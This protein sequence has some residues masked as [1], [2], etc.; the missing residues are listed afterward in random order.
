[1]SKA[2]RQIA[3]FLFYQYTE[4]YAKNSRHIFAQTC[5]AFQCKWA[6]GLQFFCIHDDKV[7]ATGP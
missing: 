4:R 3:R 7:P 2:T 1:M 6:N 5:P